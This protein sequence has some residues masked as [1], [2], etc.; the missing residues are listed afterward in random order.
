MLIA[1]YSGNLRHPGTFVIILSKERETLQ[2]N[3]N[4]KIITIIIPRLNGMRAKKD[5]A[6]KA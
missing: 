2:P 4:E 1:F 3:K 6:V 5:A